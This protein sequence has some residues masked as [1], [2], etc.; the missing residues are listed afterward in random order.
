M[1]IT[2][3][4]RFLPLCCSLVKPEDAC[5]GRPLQIHPPCAFPSRVLP[6]GTVDAGHTANMKKEK[7]RKKIARLPSTACQAHWE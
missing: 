6:S 5:D 2:Y 1:K 7:G 3:W 4:F